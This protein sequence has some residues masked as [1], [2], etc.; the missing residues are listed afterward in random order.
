MFQ[1]GGP[2]ALTVPPPGFVLGATWALLAPRVQSRRSVRV[3]ERGQAL[4]TESLALGLGSQHL[5]W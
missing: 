5:H 4:R 3:P 1:A 2:M